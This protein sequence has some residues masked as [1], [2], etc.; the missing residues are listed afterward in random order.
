MP[1]VLAV[2]ELSGNPHARSR[3]SNASFQDKGDA[4]L[5][6]YLLHLYRFTFVNKRRVTGDNEKAGDLR[7]VSDDVLGDAV[8]EIFLFRVAA[9]IVE[10][11]HGNRW[12]FQLFPL[13]RHCVLRISSGGLVQRHAVIANWSLNVLEVLLAHV[14]ESKIQSI[15]YMIAH[16]TGDHDST[17][18]G[19]AF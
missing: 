18:L 7:Q 8:T 2:D 3:L 6:T 14:L 11:K 9:H 4:K 1:P 16:G 12:S 5:V 15:A 13:C 10:W 17:G 19:N